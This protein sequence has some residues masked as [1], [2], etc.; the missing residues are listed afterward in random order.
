[1]LGRFGSDGGRGFDDVGADADAVCVAVFV[2]D[3]DDDDGSVI[4][5]A[6]FV[7][8]VVL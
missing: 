5:A 8:A 6:V 4:G 1:M 3:D 7:V 2:V